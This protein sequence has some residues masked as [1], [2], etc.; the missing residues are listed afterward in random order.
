[1]LLETT[2]ISI[3]DGNKQTILHSA[4]R[5]GHCELLKYLMIQWKQASDNNG[6]KFKSHSNE[7][8]MI[9]DW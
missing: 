6:I 4:A 9:F 5:S 3:K 1:M 8:G 2:P 7:A